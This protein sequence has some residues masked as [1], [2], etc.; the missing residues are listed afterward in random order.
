MTIVTSDAVAIESVEMISFS[1][2][3]VLAP[4]I[5]RALTAQGIFMFIRF[6]VINARYPPPAPSIGV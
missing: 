3:P 5:S 1:G 4:T 2:V 6:P